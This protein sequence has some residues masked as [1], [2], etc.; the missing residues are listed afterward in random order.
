MV[1][2]L[3][4]LAQVSEQSQ[5]QDVS[6]PAAGQP[7]TQPAKDDGLSKRID[8]FLAS[9]PETTGDDKRWAASKFGDPA[10][11]GFFSD[12]LIQQ[13]RA[14]SR[15]TIEAAVSADF[16]SLVASVKSAVFTIETRN[17]RGE[18]LKQGSAFLLDAYTVV[19]NLHVVDGA[20]SARLIGAHEEVYEVL[21]LLEADERSDLVTLAS[22]IPEEAIALQVAHEVPRE[23]ERVF[24]IGAPRGLSGT[25][26]DGLVAAV[27]QD[28]DA[29]V[30]LQIT[31]PIS[32]GS[33]GSPV[34]NG[35][36]FVIGIATSQIVEGQNLN[37]A[38]DVAR[39]PLQ[40]SGALP[41]PLPLSVWT[42]SRGREALAATA[43]VFAKI[44]ACDEDDVA[45][46][47]RLWE[48]R[49]E[50]A[51]RAVLCM[52]DSTEAWRVKGACEFFMW[53]VDIHRGRFRFAESDEYFRRARDA[54][55]T[56]THLDPNDEGAW[57]DLAVYCDML[58]LTAEAKSARSRAL[59]LQAAKAPATGP[60]PS[61]GR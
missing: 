46:R 50:Y 59:K 17:S 32:P 24:V 47:D 18:P 9:V 8:E 19:T 40:S 22:V 11:P 30:V 54:A 10:H 20:A 49:L 37:F 43:A 41:V 13:Y 36:G 14:K 60:L 26:T 6:S 48:E 45:A 57:N 3:T 35:S 25:V 23:G 38:M 58:H 61:G 53:F 51:N 2:A 39:V 1:A 55:T 34:I 27:R 56:A 33:S 7:E 28:A 29:R 44:K 5:G 21:G 31:A 42:D 15:R 16:P 4:F 52:P 12:E